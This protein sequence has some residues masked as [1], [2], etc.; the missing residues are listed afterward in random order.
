[1]VP[2]I[3]VYA[4]MMQFYRA[5]VR[6][7]QRLNSKGSS[8]IYAMFAETLDGVSTT[9]AYCR[10]ASLEAKGQALLGAMLRPWY[11]KG[12][13]GQWLNLRL[14]LMGSVVTCAAAA[15]AVFQY[16]G[17]HID[18]GKAGLV[19]FTLVHALSITDMLNGFIQ[20]F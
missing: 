9:R 5:S 16:G 20:S 8:P 15:L 17:T 2:L 12:M 13:A 6:E 19:G 3:G 18:A 10:Q 11:L 14:Q 1:M 4:R 7:L